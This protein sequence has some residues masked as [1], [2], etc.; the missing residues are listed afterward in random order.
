MPSLRGDNSG[1]IPIEQEKKPH[2]RGEC[3]CTGA[4]KRKCSLLRSEMHRSN[5]LLIF[6][7]KINLTS[8]K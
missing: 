5:N 4:H 7:F 6:I 1:G 3:C 2:L 8:F